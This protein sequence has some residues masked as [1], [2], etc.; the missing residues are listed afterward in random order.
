MLS[1][2]ITHPVDQTK[3]RS[4]TQ[5][6]RLGMLATASNTL[7]ASGVNGLWTGLSGSLL[8]QATYGSARFGIYA[9]LN[10]RDRRLRD[11]GEPGTAKERATGR[12][13]G[14]ER[15]ALVRNGAMAGVVAGIVGAPGGEPSA[16]AEEGE[17]C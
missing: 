12:K 5:R 8:R 6:V 2:T 16:V 7:R 1:V 17:R 11:V 4:Q 3:V 15:R 14:K 10:D 13:K 9:W